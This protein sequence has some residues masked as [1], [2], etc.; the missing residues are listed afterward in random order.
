MESLRRTPF[1]T[2]GYLTQ[3]AILLSNKAVHK[4]EFSRLK[5]I[6]VLEVWLLLTPNFKQD[7][8]YYFQL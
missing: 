3:Q 1:P 5:I 2:D 4:G 7:S 8:H 6:I